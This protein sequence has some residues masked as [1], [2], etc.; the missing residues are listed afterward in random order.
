MSAQGKIIYNYE[1]AKL[2]KEIV[3]AYLKF[4]DVKNVLLFLQ[5][6]VQMIKYFHDFL[7]S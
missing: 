5:Q 7:F 4:Q 2:K 1:T 6:K 3:E